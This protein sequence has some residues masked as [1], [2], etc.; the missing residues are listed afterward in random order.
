MAHQFSSN[1]QGLVGFGLDRETNENTVVC[2]LQKFSEDALMQ[3]LKSRLTDQELESIFEMISALLKR[4]LSEAEY[5]RL[6][7]KDD[8][9]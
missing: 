9:L 5:H 3:T 8:H 6:F 2:Y 7:L 4:H 1:Y